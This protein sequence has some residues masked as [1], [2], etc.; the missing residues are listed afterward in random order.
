MI[1][2]ASHL[3]RIVDTRRLAAGELNSA[4]GGVKSKGAV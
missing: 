3:M 4:F 1:V 2:L